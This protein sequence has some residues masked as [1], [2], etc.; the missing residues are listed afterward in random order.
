MTKFIVIIEEPSSGKKAVT[1][2]FRNLHVGWAHYFSN[3]WFICDP[4]DRTVQFWLEQVMPLSGDAPFAVL[5][6]ETEAWAARAPK[7]FRSWMKAVWS[8]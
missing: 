1:Q 3:V 2:I 7:S 4:E 6:V 5:K 8:Q